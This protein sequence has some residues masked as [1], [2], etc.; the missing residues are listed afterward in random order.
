[1][2]VMEISLALVIIY[3]SIQHRK[4]VPVI[5]V[6][7]QTPLFVWFEM[8]QGHK[9]AIESDL[10][11]DRMSMIMVLIIGLVGSLI[12]VYSLGYMKDFKENHKEEKDRRPWFFFLM[13]LFLSAMF[14][15]VLS[16]N[17]V[18]LYFFWEITTLCSFFLIGFTKTREVEW[19]S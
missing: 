14:G 12:C 11:I 6:L 3:L 9:I 17:L 5:F 10:Y 2:L 16:N 18:W 7:I 8:T 4:Y 13:F 15:L 19:S 1:M